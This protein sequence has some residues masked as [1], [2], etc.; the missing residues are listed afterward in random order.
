MSEQ[1]VDPERLVEYLHR[2]LPPSEDALVRAHLAE[3]AAC[4]E[5]Y[6]AEARLGDLL[7]AHAQAEEREL[8]PGVVASIRAAVGER[9]APWWSLGGRLHPVLVAASIVAGILVG[10]YFSL[11]TWHSHAIASTIDA[12]YLVGDHEALEETT[13]FCDGETLPQ[14]LVTGETDSD[15]KA[16]D[17]PR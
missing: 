8:P 6:D 15:E 2:E 3:C 4:A 1:H 13:P 10:S 11:A 9:R 16:V 7:R 12:A 14:E 17:A 5:A